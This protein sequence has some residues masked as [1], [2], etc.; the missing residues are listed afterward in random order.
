MAMDFVESPRKPSANK[1]TNHVANTQRVTKII[2][3]RLPAVES[4]GVVKALYLVQQVGK[5]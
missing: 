3:S 1:A 4:R 2:E 5:L